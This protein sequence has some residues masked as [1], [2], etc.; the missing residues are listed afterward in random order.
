MIK[1]HNDK[2]AD[3]LIQALTI[4]P[5]YTEAGLLLADYYRKRK[6]MKR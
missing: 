1:M 4:D 2:G 6:C 3:Y 5:S